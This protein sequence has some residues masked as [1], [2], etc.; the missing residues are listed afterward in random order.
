MVFPRTR[1]TLP[2]ALPLK[3][4]AAYL[5]SGYDTS[6]LLEHLYVS[7]RGSPLAS[8]AMNW[9]PEEKFVRSELR[10]SMY[11]SGQLQ[12]TLGDLRGYFGKFPVENLVCQS[13]FPGHIEGH[14]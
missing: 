1:C 14:S 7:L 2:P 4:Q 12:S 6:V 10:V 11:M 3:H 9:L 13:L 8:V 5:L